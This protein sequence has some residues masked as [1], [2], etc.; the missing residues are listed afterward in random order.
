MTM[1][2]YP[3]W[4]EKPEL[5]EKKLLAA[6]AVITVGAGGED[7][8]DMRRQLKIQCTDAEKSAKNALAATGVAAVETTPL[9][10]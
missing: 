5:A 6:R 7:S 10:G 9:S 3:I 8:E 4:M 1:W 2:T